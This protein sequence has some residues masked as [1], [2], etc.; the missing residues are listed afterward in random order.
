MS[1]TYVS[2]YGSDLQT[3]AVYIN[4]LSCS[5]NGL[6]LLCCSKNDTSLYCFSAFQNGKLD[7][8][9]VEGLADLIAA[10][11]E[12]QHRQALRQMEGDLASLYSGWTQRLVTVG[13]SSSGERWSRSRAPDCQPRG[14]WFNPTYHHFKI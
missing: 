2:L 13:S 7:L 12:L 6:A 3:G 9:E 1:L 5:V 8:T 14:C 10:E 11:T 4:S